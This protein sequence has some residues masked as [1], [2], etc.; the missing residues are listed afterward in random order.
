MR[1]V[2]LAL[3]LLPVVLLA[4]CSDSEQVTA[5]VETDKPNFVPGPHTPQAPCPIIDR[6]I[7]AGLF[8]ADTTSSLAL[9]AGADVPLE[10]ACADP[11]SLVVPGLSQAVFPP[12]GGENFIF[13][14]DVTAQVFQVTG[15]GSGPCDASVS[16]LSSGTVTLRA[17][18]TLTARGT[19]VLHTA[20]TGVVDLVSGGQA[21]LRSLGQL[22][23]RPDGSLVQDRAR[24]TLK[25]L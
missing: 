12:P 5:P 20:L 17:E 1:S 2:C 23:V 14:G 18:L 4:S 24:I 21:L 19:V 15:G 13:T 3:L 8:Q 6:T 11:Q 7:P 9:I 22:V 10:Q 16:L 25:P